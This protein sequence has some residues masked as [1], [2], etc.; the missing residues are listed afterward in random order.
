MK[1]SVLAVAF[2]LA[3]GILGFVFKPTEDQQRPLTPEPRAGGDAHDDHGHG[4]H[5]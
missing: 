4:Q 2:V 3:A 5:H 1:V